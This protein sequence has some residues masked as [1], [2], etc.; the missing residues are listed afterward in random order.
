[1]LEIPE[2]RVEIQRRLCVPYFQVG[3][4]KGWLKILTLFQRARSGFLSVQVCVSKTLGQVNKVKAKRELVKLIK[5]PSFDTI[6]QVQDSLKSV[7]GYEE[8]FQLMPRASHENGDSEVGVCEQ[9]KGGQSLGSD[10]SDISELIKF[11]LSSA[12]SLG[13]KD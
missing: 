8:I 7:P 2:E 4:V 12:L 5:G 9:F 6:L 1:M 3:A 11:N 10:W 13:S